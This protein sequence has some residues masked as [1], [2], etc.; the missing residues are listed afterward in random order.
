MSASHRTLFVTLAAQA[1]S[2]VGFSVSILA[3]IWL[4]LVP[5]PKPE[6]TE[7]VIIDKKARR[8]SAPAALP[9]PQTPLDFTVVS[10]RR[11]PSGSH[12]SSE[13]TAAPIVTGPPADTKQ[14][15]SSGGLIPP[16][17]FRRVSGPKNVAIPS[18][19]TSTVTPNASGTSS[20][21]PT[22]APAPSYFGRKATRRVST[23]VPRTQPYAHPYYA[24]PPIEDEEYVAYLR[25]LPQFSTEALARSPTSVSDPEDKEKEKEMSLFDQRGRNRKANDKAQAALGHGRRPTLLPKRSASW[26]GGKDPRL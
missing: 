8:R 14:R 3:W 7:P 18:T 17:S 21:S 9:V 12:Q 5:P 24:Q 23:P 1:I 22:A 10:V 25:N 11:I 19:A 13:D 16:W 4:S 6:L 2:S 15:R 20:A 26:A